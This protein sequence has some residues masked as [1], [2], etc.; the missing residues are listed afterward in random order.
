MIENNR[1][2]FDDKKDTIGDGLKKAD[3]LFQTTQESIDSYRQIILENE[4]VIIS[5]TFIIGVGIAWVFSSCTETIVL[6][7]ANKVLLGVIAFFATLLLISTK[8]IPLAYIAIIIISII[9]GVGAGEITIAWDS[10]TY[11]AFGTIGVCE[12]PIEVKDFL[13]SLVSFLAGTIYIGKRYKL[14]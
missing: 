9:A 7:A 12:N 1:S 14:F 8:T 11:H 5:I 3:N 6:T 10:N 2:L 4:K 13:I